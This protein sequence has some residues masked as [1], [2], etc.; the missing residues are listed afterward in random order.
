[1]IRGAPTLR[2]RVSAVALLVIAAW[3]AIVAIGFDLVVR[4]RIDSQV[5]DSLRVRAQAASTLVTVRDGVVT[6]ARDSPTDRQLDA[7]IWVYGSDGLVNH[8]PVSASLQRTVDRI[9]RHDG[10]SSGAEHRFYVLPLTFEGRAVGRVVAGV[11]TEPYDDT[12]RTVLLGS[13]VVAVL[14]L[15][16]AYPVLRIATGR[17]LR[18]VAR[19]AAR[20]AEWSVSAPAQRFGPVQRYAELRELAG[21]LD[22]LLDRLAAVLRHE[23]QLSGELSHELRT[24][25]ARLLV[26]VDLLRDRARPDQ[27]AAIDAM[28]DT[29]LAM[30]VIIDQAL[31]ATRAELVPRAARTVLDDLL[32]TYRTSGPPAVEVVP[33]PLAVGVEAGVVTRILN[34][35]VDNARRHARSRIRIAGA[36]VDGRV[37]IRVAD[38][39]PGVPRLDAER[40]FEPGFTTAVEHGHD[41]AGLG[42]ALARRLARAA[43]G[44]LFLEAA[45]DETTFVVVLPQG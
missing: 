12:E 40:I 26:E 18:P 24:P 16:G 4:T 29:C 3:V 22:E 35:V 15:A 41:G 34:P 27:R 14:V 45:T 20:A 5:S 2:G 21:R 28:H 1:V 43:D 23:R 19:M 31:A 30:N 6:G 44:D 25:L 36:G 37:E 42:L 10:F 9:A 17:A 32:Q 38:D 13:A 8:P 11:S 33:A 7:A 39:G